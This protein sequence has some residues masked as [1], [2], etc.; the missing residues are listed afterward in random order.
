M[1]VSAVENGK[2]THRGQLFPEKDL[3]KY[4]HSDK[5]IH[6]ML[7]QSKLFDLFVSGTQTDA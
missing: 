5:E 4:N 1:T 6:L 3:Q 7:Q 2:F